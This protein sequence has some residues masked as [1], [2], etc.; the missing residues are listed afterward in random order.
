MKALGKTYDD[1]EVTGV[2]FE[3]L[4]AGGYVAKITEVKDETKKEYL[5]IVYDIEEGE[6]RGFYSDEWGKEHPYAHRF[7]ASYKQTSL[8][9]FKARLKAIDDSNGTNFVQQA[10]TGLD[11]Q[12]LVGK[13]VGL[14]IGYEEYENDRGEVRERTNV[15][16]V[17]S[18]DRIR[19]GDFTVPE[20]K[21]LA[22][23]AEAPV[24]G[25][26]AINSEDLPF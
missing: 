26:E 9:L 19:R 8:G 21:K 2:D 18:V 11:E 17:C 1:T 24:A 25:F 3:R 22:P 16:A 14:I 20:L 5:S 12:K 4:P 10:V 15:K 6:K 7:V 13:L 23:K